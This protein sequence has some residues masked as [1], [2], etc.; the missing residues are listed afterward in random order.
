[1]HTIGAG[2]YLRLTPPPPL[3]LSLSIYIHKYIHTNRYNRYEGQTCIA[4]ETWS[5]SVSSE[6]WCSNSLSLSI[7]IYICIDKHID[8][9][10]YI[11]AYN[12]CRG[13]SGVN[14]PSLYIYI[15]TCIFIQICIL[16]GA[17]LHRW[18]DVELDGEQGYL[19]QQLRRVQRQVLKRGPLTA[20]AARGHGIRV[21][22]KGSP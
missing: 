20:L 3:S 2:A 17:D 7:Y 21:R 13:I 1:M 11:H 9:H 14:P 8:K 22:V 16:L 5:S 15:Y 10:I 18:R 4:G 19:A 12:R 6:T